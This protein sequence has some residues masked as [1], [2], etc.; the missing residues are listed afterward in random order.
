[1]QFSVAPP[2]AGA[3]FR[4]FEPKE[5][6]PQGSLKAHR[7]NGNVPPRASRHIE[8]HRGTFPGDSLVERFALLSSGPKEFFPQMDAQ[9]LPGGSPVVVPQLKRNER[10]KRNDRWNVPRP[11]ALLRGDSCLKL[12]RGNLRQFPRRFRT[13]VESI[14]GAIGRWV[15]I[16][17]GRSR[18]PRAAVWPEVYTRARA[19]LRQMGPRQRTT[20]L[21]ILRRPEA[22][23]RTRKVRNSILIAGLSV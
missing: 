7:G 4:S 16:S 20:Q 8:T 9:Q 6:V 13:P 22:V 21:S 23:F 11:G 15:Q 14:S 12:P 10:N 3:T 2:L 5:S 1:M 19:P 18:S 17:S